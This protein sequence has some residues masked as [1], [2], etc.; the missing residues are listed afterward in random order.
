MVY[1][2]GRISPF[3]G[4][5]A[6]ESKEELTERLLEWKRKGVSSVT[7]EY[8]E[9]NKE[10]DG[11]GKESSGALKQLAKAC[12]ELSM[13]FWIQDAAPFPTGNANGALEKEEN[14]AFRKQYL[15]ERHMDVT[16]PKKGAGIPVQSVLHSAGMMEIFG[17]AGKRLAQNLADRRLL[18]VVAYEFTYEGRIKVSSQA[19][20]WKR[21]NEEESPEVLYWD[22][23]GGYWRI[24]CVFVTSF[25]GGREYY[26]NLLDPDSVKLQIASVHEPIYEEL[27]DELL[28]TWSGFFY[29]ELEIGNTKGYDFFM[30]PGGRGEEGHGNDISQL[31]WS[32]QLYQRLKKQEN[33]I[34]K[35]PLLWYEGEREEQAAVRFGYMDE[36]TR[37]VCES[38]NGQV[39]AWCRERGIPYTGHVLEDENSHARL[40][41]GPGHYFRM[42]KHQDMAGVDLIAGQVMPQLDCRMGTY[43][44]LNGDGCFYHY[45]LAKLASSAAHIDPVKENQSLCEVFALYG[46]V[47]SVRLRKFLIDH[48]LVNGINHFI[49]ADAG[50]RNTPD[51][52]WRELDCY[53][54]AMAELLGGLK[55]LTRVA[56]L[57]HGEAQWCGEAELFQ[58]PASELARRQISYDVIPADVWADREY[59]RTDT[60]KGLTINGNTYEALVIPWCEYIPAKAAAFVEEC[61]NTGFPVFVTKAL[62]EGICGQKKE[63]TGCFENAIVTENKKL[64]EAVTEKIGKSAVRS[65]GYAP[66][67]RTAQFQGKEGAWYFLHNES[68]TESYSCE[69]IPEK[70][71]ADRMPEEEA[72]KDR[73]RRKTE[74]PDGQQKVIWA[75]DIRKKEGKRLLMENGKG[76]LMLEPF[77]AVLLLE[78][79]SLPEGY[80][81]RGE[82]KAN[83]R[84]KESIKA[85]LEGS[86]WDITLKSGETK[87]EQIKDSALFD[88]NSPS[89][90]PEFSGRIL[91]QT[92]ICLEEGSWLLKLGEV[93]DACTVY[94][95]GEIQGHCISA[96]YCVELK[97]KK[98]TD[99]EEKE[100]ADN[101]EKALDENQGIRKAEHELTIEVWN[102][103]VH[104]AQKEEIPLGLLSA[105][106]RAVK[107]QGGLIGPV[108]L[109][110]ME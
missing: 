19:V 108:R 104:T 27:K 43:G 9:R 101:T 70:E 103:P 31:P 95:D 61:R 38:Y 14:K 12:R 71:K 69:V 40:G 76:K 53:T 52:Y 78:G 17:E 50:E 42:Q 4:L 35:L 106:V 51:C 16:G 72:E 26:V 85:Y 91:Y 75:L 64:A 45:G 83:E 86:I 25:G 102:N 46:N 59:Y 11:F 73:Q 96:P 39:H 30:L 55:P 2:K 54:E 109:E 29:D 97:V 23:P 32:R 67:L 100:S 105:S 3:F 56:V 47:C 81:E 41:C 82:E 93:Y 49:Y 62:P 34:E 33:L 74:K 65:C 107:G 48:L 15:G 58:V 79:A 13:S 57:Y 66:Y 94:L 36:L 8:A 22:I 7:I 77:E 80:I 90:F 5:F 98:K 88:I 99:K 68:E 10:G 28:K 87:V 1:G 20:L 44:Y 110:K 21:Q 84:T 37:L 6:K 24:F 60:Q 89:H 92:R 63:K 18:E